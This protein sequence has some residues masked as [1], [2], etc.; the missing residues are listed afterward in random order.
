L[1]KLLLDLAI[2][3]CLGLSLPEPEGAVRRSLG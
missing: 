3:A 1:S 2:A